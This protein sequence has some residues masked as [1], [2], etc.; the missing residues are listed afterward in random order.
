MRTPDPPKQHIVRPRPPSVP[1]LKNTRISTATLQHLE[2]S[3]GC[4]NRR[5]GTYLKRDVPHGRVSLAKY[6]MAYEMQTI[7]FR[8]SLKK[9]ERKAASCDHD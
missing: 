1:D 2:E 6:V 4:V 5:G 9:K 8:L 7:F 3:D